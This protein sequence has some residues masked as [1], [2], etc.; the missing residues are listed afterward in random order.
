MQY[1]MRHLKAEAVF[2]AAAYKHVPLMEA[3]PVAVI[4]NN[5]FGTQNL[6][7]ASLDAGVK[8]FVLITTDKAV[9]PASIYGA[10]KYLSE[11][12]VE[13]TAK[14]VTGEVHFMAVRFGNVL[15]SRGSIVP[16]FQQQIEKG[17]PVTVT[18]PNVRRWFMTIPEACSLVLKAGGVGENGARY[19]L[20]M[21][22][23]IRIYTLAEH[24]IKFYGYEPNTDIKIEIIGM[25]PGEKLDEKLVADDETATPTNDAKILRL[26]R[27]PKS[28]DINR[29]A[30]LAELAPFCIYNSAYPER[31]RD[32]A[33]LRETLRAAI[34]TLIP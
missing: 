23:P 27:P 30:L 25:R 32:S 7:Q 29:T 24:L 21:G 1:I 5:V 26:T 12:L 28:E 4:E 33:A 31:Y 8:R 19:L 10:S 3:N 6:L 2:H 13:N 9:E 17:G 15:G 20:D 22:E 16:L 11:R 14:P 18:H 34:P